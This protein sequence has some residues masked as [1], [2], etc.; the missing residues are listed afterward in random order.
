MAELQQALNQ[1]A[2]TTGLDAQGA[3]NVWA[4][5]T[6]AMGLRDL[7][8]ALNYKAG[9]TPAA[10]NMR[11]LG[12]VLNQLAGTTGLGV[13]AASALITPASVYR[14]AVL[15]D[16]PVSYWRL[17]EASGTVAADVQGLHA[18]TY[19]GSPTLGAAGKVSGDAAATFLRASSQRVDTGDLS[20]FETG[21]CTY[22]LWLAT[23]AATGVNYSLF[24][25]GTS[26]GNNGYSVL[27][28]NT[29]GKLSAF[30]RNDAGTGFANNVAGPAIN[31]GIFHQC[32][33]VKSGTSILVYLDN[34]VLF[35]ATGLSGVFTQNKSC[36]A[37]GDVA[38]PADYFTG[39][40]DEV[41]VYNYALSPARIAAHFA[42]AA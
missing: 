40:L 33:M 20:L 5:I 36:I 9:N 18:G 26:A 7:V 10:L 25:E 27:L 8:G 30:A 31:D 15:A 3:A 24:S 12:G 4:G 35:T 14:Q 13:N 17:G 28:V 16:G 19:V 23:S 37:A 38:T 6:P 1:L 2:G 42:A 34:S 29:T 32:L 21:D 11:E 22:E 41:A 39:T